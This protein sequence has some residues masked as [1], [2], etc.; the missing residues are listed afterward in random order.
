[1][2]QLRR[3]IVLILILFQ[4]FGVSCSFADDFNPENLVAVSLKAL[5]KGFVLTMD[6]TKVKAKEIKKISGMSNDKFHKQ[7]QR[8]YAVLKGVPPQMR[9]KYGLAE[10]ITKQEAVEN[11]EH[12]QKK[13][14]MKFIDSV[15]D[16]LIV[17]EVN[18]YFSRTAQKVGHNPI[19]LV[20]DLWHKM[21]SRM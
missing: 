18:D 17:K 1:M 3:V 19:K 21:I 6:V 12:L 10:N 8:V 13:D 5:A 16:K 20:N 9:T 15:P 11:I 4:I 14:M 7:Y 2:I